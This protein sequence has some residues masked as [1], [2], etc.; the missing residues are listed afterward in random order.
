MGYLADLWRFYY[1][2]V[3]DFWSVK[4][5]LQGYCGI[6]ISTYIIIYC[7]II[8]RFGGLADWAGFSLVVFCTCIRNLRRRRGFFVIIYKCREFIIY[9]LSGAEFDEVFRLKFFRVEIFRVGTS[10]ERRNGLENVAQT[11][12]NY[13]NLRIFNFL[14]AI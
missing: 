12:W 3:W 8:Y 6:R 10:F 5:Y 11:G 9:K 1:V 7:V 2:Q 13:K 4:D 14:D